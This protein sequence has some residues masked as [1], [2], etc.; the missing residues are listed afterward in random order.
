MA[1]ADSAIATALTLGLIVFILRGDRLIRNR[2][3]YQI[4]AALMVIIFLIGLYLIG[5]VV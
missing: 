3:I 5:W 1:H 2:K 4:A